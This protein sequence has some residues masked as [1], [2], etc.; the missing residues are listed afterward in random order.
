MGPLCWNKLLVSTF[1]FAS[2]HIN[3]FT[4]GEVWDFQM[5]FE[6]IK[7]TKSIEA[8]RALKKELNEIN[9]KD[10]KNQNLTS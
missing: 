9:P 4:F 2:N 1:L 10:D 8:K 3:A 5:K 6:W 7:G